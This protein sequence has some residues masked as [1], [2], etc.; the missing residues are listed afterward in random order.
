MKLKEYQQ[1]KR[2]LQQMKEWRALVG[3]TYRGGGGGS[4]DVCMVSASIT[5]YF[6]EYDGAKNYHDIPCQAGQG[7]INDVIKEMPLKIIDKAIENMEASLKVT[8]AKAHE[9]AA[10]ILADSQ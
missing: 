4:G 6:Q 5:I 7:A 8:A 3:K 9:E 2:D 1:A 10:S